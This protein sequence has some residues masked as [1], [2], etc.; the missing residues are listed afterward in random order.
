MATK[1]GESVREGPDLSSSCLSEAQ[2]LSY[3][4]DTLEP[5]EKLQV[6]TH[7]SSCRDCFELFS[8]VLEYALQPPT[9]EEQA[10]GPSS[11][12]SLAGLPPPF[13]PQTPRLFS[14]WRPLLAAAAA[15]LVL[16]AGVPQYRQW[17]S[18]KTVAETRTLLNQQDRITSRE[19]LRLSGNLEYDEFTT[20]M[21][22]E[23]SA[24]LPA[25]QEKLQRALQ[26]DPKNHQAEQLLG[27][28]H[29]RVLKDTAQAEVHFRRAHA[30]APGEAAVLNDL[31]VLAWC[32]GDYEQAL[33]WFTQALQQ[34]PEFVEAQ[35]NKANLL[36]MQGQTEQARQEWQN[37]RKLASREQD[38]DWPAVASDRE[39]QLQ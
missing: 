3:L 16:F 4:E 7:L 32:R 9:T 31:G 6:E 38:T 11:R 28:F 30:L 24:P 35:F 34:K 21:G 5:Q 27:R 37:Y 13:V 2:M 12:D 39:N 17:Q 15:L 26:S 14:Y 22:P 10:A 29:L 33:D 18:R 36:Q 1:P 25:M 23:Q 8:T 20:V 19:E